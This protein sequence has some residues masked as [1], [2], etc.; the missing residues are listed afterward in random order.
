MC[1]SLWAWVGVLPV[2]VSVGA[3]VCVWIC[4]CCAVGTASTLTQDAANAGC[5]LHDNLPR[6]PKGI[7]IS[8]QV[9][10]ILICIVCLVFL[11]GC[12]GALL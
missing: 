7:G 8:K 5:S 2:S 4:A 11:C 10:G 3:C 9:C 12:L 1:I 6:V